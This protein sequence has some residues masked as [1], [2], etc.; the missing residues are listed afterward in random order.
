VQIVVT[1]CSDGAKMKHKVLF[2][3]T[4][5]TV[6]E[7]FQLTKQAYGDNALSCTWVFESYAKFR[8]GRENLEDDERS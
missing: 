3:K 2:F 4:G 7:T 1:V 6:T 8:D 5:K